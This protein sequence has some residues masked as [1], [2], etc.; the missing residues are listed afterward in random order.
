MLSYIYNKTKIWASLIGPRGH[1]SLP[2]YFPDRSLKPSISDHR[3][4]LIK[5]IHQDLDE[6]VIHILE[7]QT[8]RFLV[9]GFVEH[10]HANVPS[11]SEADYRE[12]VKPINDSEETIWGV[13]L[14][15]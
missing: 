11:A 3:T 12:I 13:L 5:G 4:F 1:K 9:G 15:H 2:S 6:H 10:H 14:R 8:Y 7:K